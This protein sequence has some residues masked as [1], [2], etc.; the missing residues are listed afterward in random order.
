MANIPTI[1]NYQEAA[2][3][4]AKHPRERLI[5]TRTELVKND[6]NGVYAIRYCYTDVVTYYPDGTIKLKTNG[7][8]TVTTKRRINQFISG[9]S[10]FQKSFNWYLRDF[11][12][13]DRIDFVEDLTFTPGCGWHPPRKLFLDQ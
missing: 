11:S 13:G 10:V 12:T 2:A 8:H 6:D 5:A 1:T 4:R 7:H 9:A 3:F